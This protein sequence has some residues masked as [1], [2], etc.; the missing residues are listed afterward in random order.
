MSSIMDSAVR[1]EQSGR[2]GLVIVDNPPVNAIS[3]SVRQGLSDCFGQ[4][5]QDASIEAVVL[6][7]DGRTFIAGADLAEFD[8][9][10][11]EPTCHRVFSVIEGMDKPVI[12]ALHGTVLGGGLETALAC[13]YR[14]AD[15]GA[16][17]GFPEI[18]LGVVPGAGGTQRLPRIVGVTTALRMLLSGNPIDAAE[19][20]SSGLVD[21]VTDEDLRQF[22]VEFA[23]RG[24]DEGRGPRRTCDAVVE[25]DDETER[26]LQAER[27]RV[28]AEMPH[29]LVPAMD[30][31]ALEAAIGE[32]FSKGLERETE[33][34]AASLATTESKAM[35]RL[36]FAE[37]A[38]SK[39]PGVDPASAR[40]IASGAIV[41]GGTMGRGIAMAFANAGLPVILMDVDRDAVENALDLIR[42]EYGR[43]VFKGRMTEAQVEERMA[44]IS[45]STKYR[46]IAAADVV[47]EAVFENMA[48]KKQVFARL[49]PVCKAGAIIATNTSTLDV[50]EIAAATGRMADVVGLHF[51]SPA[52]VM[53]L[54]EIVRTRDTGDDVLATSMQLAKKLRKVGVLSANSYGFIG[55]RMMD[56]YGREAERLLLEGATPRRIDGVLQRFGMAMGILAVYD[57]AGID[58]GYKVRQER[59]D[60]LPD[61][62]S[63]YRASSMLV[64]RGWLGQKTGIGF[65]R[66]EKGS[67]E[68]H[69]NLEA[70][71]L[72]A[73]EALRLGIAQ[74]RI[75]DEEIEQRCLFAM[76][77]EGAKVLEEG[78]ALR[79]SDIDVVYTSGY[80]FPRFRGGPMFHADTVGLGEI[81]ARI[82]GF[83][84]RLDRRH[85][86]ASGL[87]RALADSGEAIADYSNT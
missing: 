6:L 38:S 7:C 60:Q 50:A 69:D 33:L 23:E 83:A 10:I 78:V 61:D 37:R 80:G 70:I 84:E 76:I 31:D 52:Q 74:R 12:A 47:I 46:D 72:F 56:P 20:R 28:A 35:R 15:G 14:V 57:M 27:A 18:N 5:A 58:V 9:P 81:C 59:K 49:D 22:A 29:R 55:N 65:Y 73:A 68:R 36:F 62:P 54:L 21:A 11:L 3:H 30:I 64:E 17:L 13:H 66:Y 42:E 39:I 4:A 45:G 2:I 87:L 71:D 26:F 1:L 24:L 16:R 48:L 79:A 82:D 32:P 75:S 44:L 63:Y 43:R 86:Q 41:G 77:N 40:S 19:A 53:R 51:F 25:R 85:W 8:A 34:S 67:R